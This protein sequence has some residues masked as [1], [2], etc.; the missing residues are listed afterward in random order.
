MELSD[1]QAAEYDLGMELVISSDK[2]AY[3]SVW[4]SISNIQIIY[5]KHSRDRYIFSTDFESSDGK[6]VDENFFCSKKDNSVDIESNFLIDTDDELSIE[7]S[8]SDEIEDIDDF[9]GKNNG[10]AIYEIEENDKI[11]KI[12]VPFE[13]HYLY[14]GS[15]FA[16]YNRHEYFTLVRIEKGDHDNDKNKEEL[17]Y[18][19]S[20]EYFYKKQKLNDIVNLRKLNTKGRRSNAKFPFM[21][22]HPLAGTHHQ[23][24][25]SKQCTCILS[26][27][28]PPNYPGSRPNIETKMYITWKKKADFFATF[29][30]I[31]FK[32]NSGFDGNFSYTWDDLCNWIKASERGSFIERMRIKT[33]FNIMRGLKIKNRNVDKIMAMWRSRDRHLWTDLEKIEA[34]LMKQ[35]EK[36][37][38]TNKVLKEMN[39]IQASNEDK[40]LCN[41]TIKHANIAIDHVSYLI[42]RT[43]SI[44]VLPSSLKKN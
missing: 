39:K 21:I 13:Y 26:G 7:S 4:N 31:G 42:Y 27:K 32:P 30:I 9:E 25:T 35:R 1:T 2:Y 36:N 43:K 19:E 10:S 44:L 12:P 34:N 14:R 37:D 22:G 11:I 33:V 28:P 18:G 29:Y 15:A 8:D 6:Y 24:L 17:D 41:S 23:T 16:T 20:L 3:Y 40:Y 38:I 5:K